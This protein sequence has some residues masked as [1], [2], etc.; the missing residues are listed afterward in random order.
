M[1][2]E[3]EDDSGARR[4]RRKEEGGSTLT[5]TTTT[6]S[7]QVR[8]RKMLGGGISVGSDCDLGRLESLTE[9]KWG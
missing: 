2:G 4:R 9:E 5:I 8:L 7:T 1:R 6:G 3:K